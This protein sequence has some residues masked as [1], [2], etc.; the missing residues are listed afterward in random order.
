[1]VIM[2][3]FSTFSAVLKNENLIEIVIRKSYNS[4]GCEKFFLY[5][6][7]T[8]LGELKIDNSSVSTK[9]FTYQVINSYPLQLGHNYTIMDER[10]ISIDLDCSYLLRLDKFIGRMKCDAEMGAIYSKQGTT[11]RIFSPLAS[12]GFVIIKNKKKQASIYPLTKDPL[13]GV[14]EG[15]VKGDLASNTYTYLLK[16]NNSINQVIDPYSKAVTLFSKES[17]IVNPKEVFVELNEDKLLP[18]SN[19]NDAIIYET[20]IRDLTSDP[21]TEIVNKGKF[22]GFIE[23]GI[24][25][26]KNNPVGIDYLKS[27]G[28]THVQLLPVFDFQTTNDLHPE[29]TYNWGYDPENYGVVEG[30]FSTCPSDPLKRIIEYKTVISKLHQNNIRV[31]MD[32]VFNHVFNMET[33]CLEKACPNYYFRFTPEGN[34]A[35]GTFCGNEFESRHLMARKY[36]VD[37]CKYWVKEYGVD[38]FRFDL[39]GL[40]D[41]ETINEV[42]QECKKIKPNIIMYGEGWDMP[43]VMPQMQRASMNNANSLLNI[44]FFNDRFRDIV[45]GKTGHDELY[46]KGYLSGDTNYL[47]GFKH[48]FSGSVLPIAHPPLFFSPS[49]SINYVE[50]HD[51]NTIY[52]KLK[53]CCYNEDESSLLRRIKL[54]NASVMLSCGVPFFHMGQEIGLTKFGEGNSYKS[55][56]KINQFRY[57]TLDEREDLYHFFIDLVSLR[58]E[59][60]FLRLRTKEE[61]ENTMEFQS[62]NYGVLK[63]RY[64]NPQAIY[65]YKDVLIYINPT[66]QTFDTDLDD[67]YKILFNESGRISSNLYAQHLIV[68]PLSLII[69]VRE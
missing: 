64:K 13:T 62:E 68:N 66:Q 52:D 65:P 43:S 15:Y 36:I 38:G 57:N 17:V 35:D 42:Y 7:S 22:L 14:F 29:D 1:M 24:K 67:Y 12:S 19:I 54:I 46:V 40:I 28:I 50:C 20:S 18:F 47:D 5:D 55:G 25:T 30:S 45:K 23:E 10:N 61:I 63:V 48:V 41:I 56:D 16:I 11:F 44:G 39:M 49:Q 37:N 58:K 9:Y 60:K 21:D 51:N 31:V 69:C 33:S 6:D 2:N 53:A 4:K 59:M 8:L 32:V 26:K 34:K 3:A 27:L